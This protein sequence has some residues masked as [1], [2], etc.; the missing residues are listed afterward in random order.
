MCIPVDLF[1]DVVVVLRSCKLPV[2]HA[3]WIITCEDDESE[4]N[5]IRGSVRSVSES[6]ERSKSGKMTGE[7]DLKWNSRKLV[8]LSQGQFSEIMFTS[9]RLSVFLSHTHQNKAECL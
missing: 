8:S 1:V 9:T 5:K 2:C 6:R 4:K 3:R 7:K